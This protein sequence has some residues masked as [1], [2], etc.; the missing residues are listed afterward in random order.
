MLQDDKALIEKELAAHE[1]A[2]DALHARLAK[3]A[4]PD[5]AKLGAAVAKYK[6]A[7]KIFHDDCLECWKG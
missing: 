1:S 5:E 4:H 7:H 2:I 3:I 6:K